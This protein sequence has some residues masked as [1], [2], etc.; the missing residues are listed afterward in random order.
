MGPASGSVLSLPRLCLG[1]LLLSGPHI[2]LPDWGSL[3]RGLDGSSG[4][5]RAVGTAGGRTASGDGGPPLVPGKRSGFR[6]GLL[7]PPRPRVRLLDRPILRLLLRPY[8]PGPGSL[9][10]GEEPPTS[11]SSPSEALLLPLLLLGDGGDSRGR[12]CLG[13]G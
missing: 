4:R 2:L 1:D 8:V 12:P 10:R 7:T 6:T 11:L 5:R 9:P 13:L 3:P